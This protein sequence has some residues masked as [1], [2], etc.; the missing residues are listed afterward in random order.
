[1]KIKLRTLSPV[2][3]GSGEEISPMEYFV[4]GN[5]SRINM[6]RLFE[7][8]DFELIM[9]DF[10]KIAGTQRYIGDQV[11]LELLKKHSLYTIPI[12]EAAVDY[13]QDHQILVKSFAKSASRVFIPGS[14]IKGA[15]LS[16]LF[17]FVLKDLDLQDKRQVEFL[18]ARDRNFNDLL[19]FIFKKMAKDLRGFNDNTFRFIRWIDVEDSNLRIPED[20]LEISLVHIQGAKTG[21]EQPVLFETLK[22]GVEF[23]LKIKIKNLKFPENQV[24]DIC[25]QFYNRVLKK[26][27]SQNIQSSSNLLRLGQGSSAFATSL[28]ILAEDLKINNY[29]I[30]PP[31]T[32]KRIDEYFALGWINLE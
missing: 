15:I 7:D 21:K 25:N 3:I 18:I 20:V 31:I 4:N 19:N 29:Q 13:L 28:L 9:E 17:W 6:N 30:S 2:H 10:I 12:R 26:D 8:A 22:S 16:A 23:D 1:M 11:P 14:S 24:L 5:F 32:R 27:G